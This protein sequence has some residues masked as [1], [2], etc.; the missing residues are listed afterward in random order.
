MIENA[1]A[2]LTGVSVSIATPKRQKTTQL[3]EKVQVFAQRH[4]HFIL[5]GF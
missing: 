2:R 4:N 5:I 3:R 1:S